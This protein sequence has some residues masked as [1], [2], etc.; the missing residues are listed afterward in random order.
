MRG[1]AALAIPWTAP[2]Q[3]LANPPPETSASN[4]GISS[5]IFAKQSLTA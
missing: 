4:S 1:L 3:C 2:K 5:R